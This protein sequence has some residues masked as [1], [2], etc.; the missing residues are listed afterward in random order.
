MWRDHPFCQ[1]DMT[2]EKTVWV[3]V[4]AQRKVGMGGVWKKFE[5]GVRG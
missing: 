5:K 3:V 2:T 1:I 4:G